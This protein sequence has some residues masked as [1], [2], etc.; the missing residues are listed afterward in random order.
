MSSASIHRYFVTCSPGLEELLRAELLELGLSGEPTPGG[1]SLR[2]SLTV[3]WQAAFGSRLAESI[4]LRLKPFVA[5]HFAELEAGLLKLPFHAYLAERSKIDV[6]VTCASSK[7]YHTDAV[8]ERVRR[9][10]QSLG[11]SDE[12]AGHEDEPNPSSRTPVVGIKREESPATRTIFVRIHR[13]EVTV[14]VDA[15]GNRLHRRGYR[16]HV[17]QAPIRETLAAAAVRILQAHAKHRLTR[18]WDP[19][20]GSGT[21]LAEWMQ[22]NSGTWPAFAGTEERRYAFE[23]WPVHPEKE[24][25]SWR[26]ANQREHGRHPVAE[27]RAFGSDR[28][29]KTLEA[30]RH[31][32]ENAGV[33]DGCT[34]L[35]LDFRRAH[36]DVPEGTAVVS[37]LP[38]GVRLKREHRGGPG[39]Y[40]ALDALLA[41]RPDLRPALVITNTLPPTGIDT[42]GPQQR[43]SR[44]GASQSRP[45]S[46]VEQSTQPGRS[47]RTMLP[48]AAFPIRFVSSSF[49]NDTALDERKAP[50]TDLGAPLPSRRRSC[51]IRLVEC[52]VAD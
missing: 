51:A 19:C 20:C 42:P 17:G 2:G 16:T 24:F 14:S 43:A 41:Q 28:D 10:L 27:L 33:L 26:T 1:V 8:E 29:V 4:R 36:T 30:A 44:T 48:R 52:L 15:T 46:F 50:R 13:N 6:R 5:T 47:R 21:M 7:L 3:L 31:N 35:P 40:E 22:T 38:Y 9:V 23:G 45:G 25:A 39:A 18:I 32:L 37:N 34:L 12:S 49:G 11:R